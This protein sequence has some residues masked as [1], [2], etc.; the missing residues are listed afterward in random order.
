MMLIQKAQSLGL[1]NF[2]L[3]ENS[4][5]PASLV[6]PH[7]FKGYP[8][9]PQD[10]QS[11][12]RQ[13]N[14][15]T[16]ESEFHDAQF[17][18]KNVD[19]QSLFIYPSLNAL[20]L[21]QD[22]KTQKE[23]FKKAQLPTSPFLWTGNEQEIQAFFRQQ[24]GLVAKK[25]WNGY[26][27]YGTY[28]LKNEKKLND[29]LLEHSSQLE[30]FI[31]EK[32]IS[33]EFEMA[34]QVARSRSGQISFFPFVKTV[35]KDNKC[36]LV[37]GPEKSDEKMKKQIAKFL[38]QISYV[39]VAGFEFFKTRSGLIVNEM[40]PRVH[41]TGHHTLDSC[42]VDQ[43]TMHWLCATQDQ[44]PQVQIKARAFAMLN[45]I[46]KGT[47]EVQIPPR[48]NGTLFWY[49]KTNR[50]GRKLGHI[51]FVGNERKDLEKKALQELKRWKL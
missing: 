6:A 37:S 30:N 35:Q 41:N 32:L 38:N 1:Q 47:H 49:G 15:L 26:D 17:L 7:F 18:R 23:S 19:S 44:L 36:F 34:V 40:A 8:N 48:K 11:F 42:T 2:V 46:G 4:H 3:G 9:Q 39:G 31:F 14:V 24:K 43:F 51:N 27:G 21:I 10:L 12:C 20:Q 45:L 5:S 33:F 22:R 16:F 28:I 13:L 29:F 25:R 50:P